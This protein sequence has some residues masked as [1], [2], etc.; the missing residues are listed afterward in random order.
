L[1]HK[2]KAESYLERAKELSSA[3][4]ADE[5]KVEYLNELL[6]FKE[7]LNELNISDGSF[8]KFSRMMRPILVWIDHCRALIKTYHK[9]LDL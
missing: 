6:K 8:T 1:D 4:E 9:S 5:G 2:Q 7:H 3:D